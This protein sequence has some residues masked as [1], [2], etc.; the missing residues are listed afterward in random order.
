MCRRGFPWFALLPIVIY[1]NWVGVWGR[2][3]SVICTE[4]YFRQICNWQT[5]WGTWWYLLR[6]GIHL[7]PFD[8]LT[9][10]DLPVSSLSSLDCNFISALH[11]SV[12]CQGD[13]EGH[14]CRVDAIGALCAPTGLKGNHSKFRH[15]FNGLMIPA[16][17]RIC[18]SA[19]SHLWIANV[20]STLQTSVLCL[21]LSIHQFEEW[22]WFFNSDKLK[23]YCEEVQLQNAA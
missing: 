13:L 22:L 17:T 9:Y 19:H 21:T 14:R 12:S 1:F 18:W 10:K 4:P 6:M 23:L 16:H 3:W 20:I 15:N 5:Y 11:N 7:C 2:C 8:T